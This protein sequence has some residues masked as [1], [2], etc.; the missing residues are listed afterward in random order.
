MGLDATKPIL[1]VSDK[2]RLEPVSSAK[3]MQAFETYI[4]PDEQQFYVQ[5]SKGQLSKKFSVKL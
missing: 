3:E 5:N 1:K 4:G 2:A